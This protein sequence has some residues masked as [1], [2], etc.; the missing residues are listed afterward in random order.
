MSGPNSQGCNLNSKAFAGSLQTHFSLEA[1]ANVGPLKLVAVNEANYSP[2]VENFSLLFRGPLAPVLPQCIYRLT[3][4]TLGS[5]EIFL[6]PVGPDGEG[7]QYE[8]V[9]NRLL[10]DSQ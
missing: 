5:M 3:H 4:D 10:S 2:K 6:V 1:P 7:M 8:A 9:F